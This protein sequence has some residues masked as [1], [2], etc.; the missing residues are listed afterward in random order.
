MKMIV[1]V[2]IGLAGADRDAEIEVEDGS[3]NEEIE[4]LARE[5]MFEMVEWSWKRVD[6]PKANRRAHAP[7]TDNRARRDRG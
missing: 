6:P 4:E 3:T 2:S 5:A 1:H 7:T